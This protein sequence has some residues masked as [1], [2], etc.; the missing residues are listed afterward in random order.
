MEKGITVTAFA[1][2][3]ISHTTLHDSGAA[4]LVK[5]AF[6]S[7]VALGATVAEA[8]RLRRAYESATTPAARRAVVEQFLRIDQ[9]LHTDGASAS[10]A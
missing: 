7:T 1:G 2:Q 6:H 4:S 10:A 5:R 3:R 8:F 9:S